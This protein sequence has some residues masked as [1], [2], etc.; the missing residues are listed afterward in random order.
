[1][2][3]RAEGEIV[4]VL[5]Y[6]MCCVCMDSVSTADAGLDLM[7]LMKAI[8]DRSRG[9]MIGRVKGSVRSRREAMATTTAL[10]SSEKEI[11]SDLEAADRQWFGQKKSKA[12]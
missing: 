1:M 10:S 6:C 9:G 8:L 7:P 5:D 3:G 11:R 12:A 2:R 4:G